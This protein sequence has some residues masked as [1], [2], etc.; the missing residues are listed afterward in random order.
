MSRL[1]WDKLKDRTYETGTDQ[2]VL[3]LRNPD[4]TYGTGVAWNGLTAVTLN[5]SGAEATAFWADN[6]KYLNILSAEELGFTLEAYSYPRSFRSCLGRVD[7]WSGITVSQQKRQSFGFC[8]RS[9]V[10]N[11]EAGQDYSYKLHVIYGCTASPSSKN[12]TTVND[13]P[14]AITLSWEVS[15]LPVVVEG[16]KPTSE[17]VFDGLRYKKL[18]IMNI[19]HAIEKVL[20]GTETTEARLPSIEEIQ[21]IYTWE[22]YLRDNTGEILTT[23]FGDPLLVTA[24]D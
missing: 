6:S 20:Y 11:A 21:E 24:Y 13:S 22:R 10:G 8:F 4:G 3:Y 9:K 23:N 19:L 18:G 2:G 17:F 16:M 7:L 1:I 14:E 5:P 12:Y 15:T